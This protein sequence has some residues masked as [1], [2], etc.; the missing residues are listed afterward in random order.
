MRYAVDRCPQRPVDWRA[1]FPVAGRRQLGRRVYQTEIFTG[2]VSVRSW[3]HASQMSLPVLQARCCAQ[4]DLWER[5]DWRKCLFYYWSGQQD[6]NLPKSEKQWSKREHAARFILPNSFPVTD[7]WEGVQSLFPD[8]NLISLELSDGSNFAPSQRPTDALGRWP[9]IR[10]GPAALDPPPHDVSRSR[11]ITASLRRSPV[12]AI[13]LKN[14]P[15]RLR[16]RY[17]GRGQ[18]TVLSA[19]LVF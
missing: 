4:V 8:N 14:V 3:P 16:H 19:V 15:E 1:I 10:S 5:G 9:D 13:A 17:A 7:F 12:V 6:S 11:S 2:R 18:L